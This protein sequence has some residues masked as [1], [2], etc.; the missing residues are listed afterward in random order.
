MRKAVKV[1]S[2]VLIAASVFG[3]VGG[4]LALKDAL[5]SKAYWEAA[6]S[7]GDSIGMLEDGLNQLKEN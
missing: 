7:G 5:G 3:L 4:G 1:L 6:S 2:V